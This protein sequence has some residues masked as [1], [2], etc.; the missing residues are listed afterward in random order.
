MSNDISG[1]VSNK[2]PHVWSTIPSS[3][4]IN[5]SLNIHP[6]T[7]K[8]LRI[9]KLENLKKLIKAATKH[10]PGA[11]KVIDQHFSDKSYS[12]F[13]H[14]SLNRAKYEHIHDHPF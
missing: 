12:S 11:N 10:L 9:S 1:D 7:Q 3:N 4:G 2:P 13:Q 6:A 8:Q 5:A 14:V